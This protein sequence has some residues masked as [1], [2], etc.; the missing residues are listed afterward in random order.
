[1]CCKFREFIL[2]MGGTWN[3]SAYVCCIK[4]SSK[5]AGNMKTMV[6]FRRP[7]PVKCAPCFRLFIAPFG[8]DR[9]KNNRTS[10]GNSEEKEKCLTTG[11]CLNAKEQKMIADQY[12]I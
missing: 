12:E 8:L 4:L 5:S 2:V 9:K 3:T 11:T 6:P 10:L 7:V 1:M